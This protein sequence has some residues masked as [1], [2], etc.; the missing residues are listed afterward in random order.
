MLGT[1][2][3][4][5]ELVKLPDLSFRLL[6]NCAQSASETGFQ[7]VAY[8]FMEKAYTIYEQDVTDS[9]A[10]FNAMNLLIPTLA[11]LKL[12]EEVRCCCCVFPRLISFLQ[13]SMTLLAKTAQHSSR[14]LKK[15][16]QCALVALVSHLFA[17]PA[18]VMECMQRAVR[19]ASGMAEAQAPLFALV[20]SHYL[21]YFARGNENVTP[22]FL[23]AILELVATKQAEADAPVPLYQNTLKYLQRMKKEQPAKYGELKF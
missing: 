7:A 18:R 9:V 22:Q 16:D 8:Q 17:D 20:L 21:Y 14:V 2:K 12:T 19:I 23:N 6:L 10:Q 13:D 15:G 11:T 5:V 1:T 3:T 4:F